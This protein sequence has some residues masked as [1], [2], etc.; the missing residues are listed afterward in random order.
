[1][2]LTLFI[3]LTNNVLSN[4][5]KINTRLHTL[6]LFIMKIIYAFFVFLTM[7]NSRKSIC[8]IIGIKY[9]D[10]TLV[11]I[12]DVENWEACGKLCHDLISPGTCEYWSFDTNGDGYCKLEGSSADILVQDEFISGDKDCYNQSVGKKI[13]KHK[14]I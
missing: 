1:M 6:L 7:A 10:D 12:N 3:Y 8:P 14:G 13:S 2:K 4:K 11:Q 9:Y 5:P